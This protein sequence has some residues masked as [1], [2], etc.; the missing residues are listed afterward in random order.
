MVNLVFLRVGLTHGNFPLMGL[1]RD[2]IPRDAAVSSSAE[3]LHL[4]LP[5]S[6]SLTPLWPLL[7]HKPL[8]F[9]CLLGPEF[10]LLRRTSQ[11]AQHGHFHAT[12][13]FTRRL[14]ES[15]MCEYKL[16][17]KIHCHLRQTQLPQGKAKW[18]DLFKQQING[19]SGL[20]TYSR[21]DFWRW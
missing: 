15:D 12:E 21:V 6:I 9:P 8:T 3:P 16:G 20:R 19:N 14:E 17:R 10:V 13:E 18:H 7:A 11:P 4:L 2:V 1:V 5:L